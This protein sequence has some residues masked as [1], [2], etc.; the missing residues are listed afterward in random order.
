MHTQF[1]RGEQNWI[2]TLRNYYLD[3]MELKRK[4]N[5]ERPYWRCLKLCHIHGHIWRNVPE[6][7][8]THFLHCASNGRV[9]SLR[10]Q[11]ETWGPTAAVSSPASSPPKLLLDGEFCSCQGSCSPLFPESLGD[12]TDKR[13]NVPPTA[14]QGPPWGARHKP[15]AQ[16]PTTSAAL[17]DKM[18]TDHSPPQQHTGAICVTEG[19]YCQSCC[20]PLP[21]KCSKLKQAAEHFQQ[22]KT[23]R[24]CPFITRLPLWMKSCAYLTPKAEKYR[25]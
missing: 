4:C 20:S 2:R 8:G 6:D 12:E 1:Y 23:N 5:R 9:L 21:P 14:P 17:A 7:R 24:S 18:H 13:G 10:P 25:H 3:T 16:L 15:A 11:L 22:H 19:G